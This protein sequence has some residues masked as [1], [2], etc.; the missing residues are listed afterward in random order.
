MK[1][2]G[3][4]RDGGGGGEPSAERVLRKVRERLR[5]RPEDEGALDMH[6]SND[7]NG[8]ADNVRSS[9]LPWGQ[10]LPFPANGMALMTSSGAKGSMVNF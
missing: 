4:A 3:L 1:F 9:C 2:T 7:L 8:I 5:S 6:T 10:R